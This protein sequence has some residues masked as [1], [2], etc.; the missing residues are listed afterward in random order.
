MIDNNT[1]DR[2]PALFE[3]FLLTAPSLQKHQNDLVG[4]CL[5]LVS[6]SF[7]SSNTSVCCMHWSEPIGHCSARQQLFWT[8]HPPPGD[9]PHALWKR[10]Y[11]TPCFIQSCR[12]HRSKMHFLTSP[13]LTTTPRR[14]LA[15]VAVVLA[16]AVHLFIVPRRPR[17]LP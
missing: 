15:M 5:D 4:T 9:A 7:V 14:L 6:E 16:A 17:L 1:R 3:G 8:V 10:L 12:H 11:P 2:G 13:G